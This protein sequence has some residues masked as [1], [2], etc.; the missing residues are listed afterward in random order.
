VEGSSRSR[1]KG[2]PGSCQGSLSG[3][4]HRGWAHTSPRSIIDAKTTFSTIFQSKPKVSTTTTTTTTT[5]TNKLQWIHENLRFVSDFDKVLIK[6][7]NQWSD[8]RNLLEDLSGAFRE[9]GTLRSGPGFQRNLPD[10]KPMEGTWTITIDI[11]PKQL[12]G[13][14]IL[15][16]H[17][18]GRSVLARFSAIHVH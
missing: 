16:R 11:D 5:T 6:D 7:S 13:G 10:P 14:E 9:G 18:P 2:Y 1:R 15:N 4:F 3:D 8:R 12:P 17:R